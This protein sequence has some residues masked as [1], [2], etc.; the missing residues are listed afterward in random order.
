[1]KLAVWANSPSPHQ[2]DF[3]AALRDAGVDLCVGYFGN[4]RAERRRLGWR[5][6]DELPPGERIIPTGAD[7]LA[8]LDDWRDRVHVIPGYSR[9]VYWRLA[10]RLAHAG[11]PWMH[12]SENSR[13]SW[14]SPLVW[15]GKRAWGA[16]VNRW[17][18]GALAQGDAA[19]RDFVRWGIRRERI[20]HLY[21]AVNGAGP[22][23]DYDAA[24]ARFVAGRTA[25]VAVGSVSR[26]KATRVLVEAF[27]TI[28]AE[29]DDVCLVVVGDGPDRA[30]CEQLAARRG[31]AD[32]VLWRG[33]VPHQQ[34]PAVLQCA[35]VGVLASRYDGWGVALNEAASAGLALI[36]ADGVGATWRLVEPGGNGFRVR[37]GSVRSLAAAMRAYAQ[38]PEL[39]RA[40][41][42]RSLELFAEFTPQRSVERLQGAVRSW[43]AARPEW[44]AW[45]DDW[46]EYRRPQ[47]HRAAA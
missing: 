36:A 11:T 10:A 35:A 28:A 20:A 23:I 31:V 39:A 24:T 44:A 1:M 33:V 42:R 34:V 38:C 6:V 12:W 40:H 46:A 17:A 15:P 9:L 29:S 3:Y 25:L 7:P 14:R 5:S 43:L 18:L 22:V 16:V 26:N 13:P 32:R 21:Y 37:S 19:E 8:W 47:L 41:G 45:R 30:A 27:A 4:L 2:A